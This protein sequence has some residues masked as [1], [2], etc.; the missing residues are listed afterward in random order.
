MAFNWETIPNGQYAR[1]SRIPPG[2]YQFEMRAYTINK[3]ESPIKTL[4]VRIKPPFWETWWFRSFA[5]LAILG[6]IILGVYF[7]FREKIR[8]QRLIFEKEKATHE[9]RNRIASELHDDLGSELSTILFLSENVISEKD[10]NTRKKQLKKISESSS[11]LLDQTRDIIWALDTEN[12]SL[13]NLIIQ[14]RSFVTEYTV[15]NGLEYS[16]NFPNTIPEAELS[17]EKR[18][19]I[20][21]MLKEGLR[22]VVK[23]AQ[24]RKVI[25]EINLGESSLELIVQDDGMGFREE[26]K[27]AKGHGLNNLKKRAKAVGGKIDIQSSESIGTRIEIHIPL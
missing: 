10:E 3:V 25:V 19:N 21:L 12:D 27:A 6:I 23:H 14:L 18:R 13:E 1:F 8:E 20:L 24:A 22:N 17:G 16:L 26:T 4:L 5:V 7:Y 15:N 9:E 11:S 2:E